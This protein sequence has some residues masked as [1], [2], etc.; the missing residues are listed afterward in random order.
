MVAVGLM[1]A[2]ACGAWAGGV[3]WLQRDW[4][5]LATLQL[6]LDRCVRDETLLL[7]SRAR[8]VDR[9]GERMVFLRRA[10]LVA[11]NPAVAAATR[12]TLMALATE[13][14]G[15]G[16]EWRG[17]ALRWRVRP[18]AGVRARGQAYPAWPYVEEAADAWGPRP[19]RRSAAPGG[20]LIQARASPRAS[21]ARIFFETSTRGW[22]GAWSVPMAR[23]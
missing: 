17:R 16:L 2:L 20:H 21:A 14:R 18:C 15:L 7:R 13:Q 22:R 10:L 9:I 6:E 1:L 5:R 12:A 8:A 11:P 3:T 4:T 23:L 19:L